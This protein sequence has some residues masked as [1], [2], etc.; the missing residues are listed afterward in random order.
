MGVRDPLQPSSEVTAGE[1]PGW[2]AV[3]RP[4]PKLGSTQ[5]QGAGPA[6]LCGTETQHAHAAGSGACGEVLCSCP[7]PSAS[8]SV[9]GTGREQCGGEAPPTCSFQNCVHWKTERTPVGA[10]AP[11]RTGL[12]RSFTPQTVTNRCP[13]QPRGTPRH[14][15]RALPRQKRLPPGLSSEPHPAAVG[16]RC[17]PL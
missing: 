12:L 13:Q 16:K 11:P 17:P 6:H 14:V 8:L 10:A 5:A 2:S 1:A 7:R 9:W 15:R 4:L 3:P